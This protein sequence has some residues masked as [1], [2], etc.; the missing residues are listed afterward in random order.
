MEPPQLAM[1]HDVPRSGLFATFYAQRRDDSPRVGRSRIQFNL[2]PKWCAGIRFLFAVKVENKVQNEDV[3]VNKAEAEK[4]LSL[5]YVRV[6]HD[7]IL[8]I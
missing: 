2:Q 1:L 5:R 7:I 4:P 8:R 6:T 3:A